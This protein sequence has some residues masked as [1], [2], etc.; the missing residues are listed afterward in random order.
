MRI[1]I[2]FQEIILTGIQGICLKQKGKYKKYFGSIDVVVEVLDARIPVASR[3]PDLNEMIINKTSIKRVILLNK[4]DLADNKETKKWKEYFEKNDYKVIETIGDT[5]KGIDEL[6][7]YLESLQ[8]G[9]NTTKTIIMGIPNVGKS[10]IINK[11][12]GKNSLEAK[13]KAGVT[14]KLKWVRVNDK[15]SIIDSPGMLWPKFEDTK[16]GNNLAAVR[17]YKR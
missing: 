14:K 11:L 4:I 3:N 10:T 2:R 6:K 7:R 13:N 12:L 17:K 9:V 16:I 1:M 8:K 5:G 15:I